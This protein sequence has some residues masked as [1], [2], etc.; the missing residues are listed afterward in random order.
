[1]DDSRKTR[2][3]KV[4]SRDPEMVASLRTRAENRERL[5]RDPEIADPGLLQEAKEIRQLI[6]DEKNSERI[7]SNG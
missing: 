6:G 1:M 3:D 5:G 4:M 7:I 2:F